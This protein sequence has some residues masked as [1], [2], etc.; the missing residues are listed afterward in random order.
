[1]VRNSKRCRRT[2]APALMALVFMAGS[3]LRGAGGAEAPHT[4][5][6]IVLTGEVSAGNEWKTGF[7]EG[8]VF[9]VLPIPREKAAAGV[10]G[11][12]LV[13]D[14]LDPAGFPDALLVA[15]PPYNL[16][17]SREVGTSFGLR[18]QDAIGWNPRHFHFMTNRSDF[19][20]AQKAYLFLNRNGELGGQAHDAASG[21]KQKALHRAMERFEK[22]ARDSLPGEF[23]ILDARLTPGAAKAQPYAANWAFQSA[24]TPHT[25]EVPAG[26]AATPLGSLQWMQ[27]SVTLWVPGSWRAP[28]NIQQPP[29]PCPQ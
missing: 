28:K 7:G 5:R 18:A 22:L 26:G 27:F 6:K 11:W 1:M 15:N 9:R 3:G 8:W 20:Q 4:C 24:K 23:R 19:R 21:R 10:G 25:D 16:I 17:N 29:M 12:D 2:A 14:R 13:V